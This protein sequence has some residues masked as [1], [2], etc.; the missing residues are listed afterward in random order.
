MTGNSPVTIMR[1][2][3]SKLLE[4]NKK[5]EH[6]VSELQCEVVSIIFLLSQFL[7]LSESFIATIQCDQNSIFKLNLR[8]YSY[9]NSL[10]SHHCILEKNLFANFDTIS[11]SDWFFVIFPIA[12]T[13]KGSEVIY[14]FFSRQETLNVQLIDY[15]TML[16]E[17][18][19]GKRKLSDSK[20]EHFRSKMKSNFFK[21]FKVLL[22]S[23]LYLSFNFNEFLDDSEE[24]S[25]MKRP[26]LEVNP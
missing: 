9:N 5:A 11:F 6:K 15:Y 10:P 2:L 19:S 26:K 13:D 12:I 18:G 3:V 22:N 1:R 17:G 23:A 4:R 24:D 8:L 16:H 21:E 14:T 25:I 7:K 20:M